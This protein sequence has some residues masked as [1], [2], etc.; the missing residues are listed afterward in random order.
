MRLV[1]ALV[2]FSVF[3]KFRL[4]LAVSAILGQKAAKLLAEEGSES[5]RDFKD[6]HKSHRP[7]CV[8]SIYNIY[9]L[10]TKCLSLTFSDVHYYIIFISLISS[11]LRGPPLLEI[12]QSS[13]E[14]VEMFFLWETHPPYTSFTPSEA[15]HLGVAHNDVLN[16]CCPTSVS[17]SSN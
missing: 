7:S 6:E 17:V 15:M 2:Q 5:Q 9:R 11:S 8:R 14:A 16:S 13:W 4:T 3:S 10:H 1:C 12:Y